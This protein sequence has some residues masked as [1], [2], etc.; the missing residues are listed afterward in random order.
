MPYIKSKCHAGRTVEYEYY[1]TFRYNDGGGISRAKKEKPTRSAQKQVNLRKSAKECTRLLNA[2]FGTDDLY[3]TFTYRVESRPDEMLLKKHIRNLLDKLRSHQK[4]A[5]GELK[6]VWTAEMG[7]RGATHI[8]MVANQ[9][10]VAALRAA[11]KH[12]YV[13]IT[14]LDDT[15]QY[16]ALAEYL[17]KYANR[18]EEAIGHH[19]GR[20]YNPSRNL[21]RPEP[22]RNII[23][24]RRKI[25]EHIPVP[26][27]YYLDK[28]SER[29][30][31]HEVTGYEYLRYTLI[32]LPERRAPNCTK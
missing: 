11:W 10:P 5:G 22:E 21:V 19:I 31:I 27:G 15:G 18:T 29:R 7:K 25:P 6:Y 12:G 20:R 2:N 3:I 14:P 13:H 16:Q 24:G 32:R 23:I 4:K 1:Y 17:V 8:H 28:Q 30:G 9:M 26:K